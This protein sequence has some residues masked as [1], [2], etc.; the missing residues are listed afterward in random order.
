MKN[1]KQWLATAAMLL[2]SAAS[3]N[4]QNVTVV[5]STGELKVVPPPPVAISVPE[6]MVI[7]EGPLEVE[8]DKQPFPIILSVEDGLLSTTS[9]NEANGML[10]YEF[11][12]PVITLEGSSNVLYF[13]F[14]E[15]HTQIVLIRCATRKNAF[16]MMPM[17]RK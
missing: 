1:S 9:I 6:V 12:S 13:T 8:A 14:L 17:A 7:E 10:Q 15:T 3:M 11:T 4:A 5:T 16:Y 2:C